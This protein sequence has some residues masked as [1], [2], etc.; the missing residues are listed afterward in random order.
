MS[1]E[2][3]KK[4]IAKTELLFCPPK[5]ALSTSFPISVDGN[6]IFPET[7]AKTPVVL[8]SSLSLSSYV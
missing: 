5:P 3:L 2:C 7:Q 1:N 6:A 4:D 8:D